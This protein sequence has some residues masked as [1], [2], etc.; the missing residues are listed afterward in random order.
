MAEHVGI[1]NFVDPYLK[2]VRNLMKRPDSS[3][4]LQVCVFF[5]FFYCHVGIANFVDPYLKTVRNL[6]KRP[7]SSFLLQVFFFLIA[8][9]WT[10]TSRP[11]ATS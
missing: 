1:A 7:D 4:L 9:L 6:M 5:I 10:P 11:C 3:F 2:T 8:S